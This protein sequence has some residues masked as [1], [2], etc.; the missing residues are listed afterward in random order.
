MKANYSTTTG[1]VLIPKG[2]RALKIGEI[3]KPTDFYADKF[4]DD[5]TKATGFYNWIGSN[6]NV[7]KYNNKKLTKID[8]KHLV[9]IRKVEKPKTVNP[10]YQFFI[11]IVNRI[12]DG[13]Y[14]YHYNQCDIFWKYVQAVFLLAIIISYFSAGFISSILLFFCWILTE[15]TFAYILGGKA[16]RNN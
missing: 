13:L 11:N 16:K 1:K 2:Y 14:Y 5:N 3:E 10:I 8:L 9:I 12:I 6:N 4:L 15:T 7:N